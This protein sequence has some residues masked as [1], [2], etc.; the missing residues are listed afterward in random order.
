MR[1]LILVFLAACTY[2]VDPT[3]V[4]E[5]APVPSRPSV[6]VR[7][8][9]PN[10]AHNPGLASVCVTEHRDAYMCAMDEPGPNG[11]ECNKAMKY[12]SFDIWCCN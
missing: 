6:A 3:P 8:E 10:C 4:P 12:T 7:F 9:L 11:K 2:N 5:P 1:Y